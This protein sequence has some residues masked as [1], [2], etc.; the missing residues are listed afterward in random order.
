MGPR[1]SSI[2]VLLVD[3]E[4]LIVKLVNDVLIKLG[5]TSILTASSGRQGID[6]YRRK[7]VDLIISDWRMEDMDG[8][9]L[10][11]FVRTSPQ[12]PNMRT[13]IILLTGNTE[14]KDVLLARDTGVTEYIIKP[15][16][17]RQLV[18]RI[19]FVIEKPRSF[20]ETQSFR[21]PDR[22][23]QNKPPLDGIEKRSNAA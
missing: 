13:P 6:L 19:R 18:D 22:R 9:D 21:G 4:K 16:S 2:N 14:R 7:P 10:L 5:F 8:M 12:S 23:R 20:I 1:L 3:D 15:F 11:R 17:A